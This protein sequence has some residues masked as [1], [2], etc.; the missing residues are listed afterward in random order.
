MGTEHPSI[1]RAEEDFLPWDEL[2]PLIDQLW[3]ACQRLDCTK[4]RETLLHAVVGYSPTS[5]VED[6]VW[7]LRKD[8][9]IGNLGSKVTALEPRRLPPSERH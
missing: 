5:Q 7:R 4:A 9:G 1:M 6:L 3:I 2:K 8:G